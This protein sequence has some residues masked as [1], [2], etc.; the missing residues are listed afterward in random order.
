MLKN[1]TYYTQPT[2]NPSRHRVVLWTTL[3]LSVIILGVM[4]ALTASAN[5]PA[6]ADMRIQSLVSELQ[7]D[8]LT[9][10]RHAAQQ[11]L[12]ELG[13]DAVPAL[14][15]ALRS[16]NAVL[17]RNAADML[18]FIASPRSISSLQYSLGNDPV[19][20]V[21]RNAA[22]AL[23][24][25]DS[26][27][28]VGDLQKASLFDGSNLVRQTAQD[29]IARIRTRLALTTGIPETELNAFTVSPQS[30]SNI[31]VATRRDIVLTQDGG[32][33][34]RTFPNALPSVSNTLTISPTNPQV[35]YA[36]ID[37]SGMYKSVD[38]GRTWNAMN[39]GLNVA[40]GAR[41]VV[42]AITVDP[43]EPQR[44]IIATGMMVGTSNVEFYS[45]GIMI[46]NNG[47][48]DWV[49]LRESPSRDA[50]TQL[51]LRGNQLYAL[52][53]DRVVKYQFN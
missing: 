8:R 32:K 24:E 12:E 23:G 9:A 33:T 30:P 39:N 19:P 34:W 4:V 16:D 29:S 28:A 3:L 20:S 6:A 22:F 50:L 35:L 11:D 5:P 1:P 40:P 17:R 10:S 14:M 42:T 21:R 48:E 2:F 52:A 41:F 13:E 44:V 25:I 53:G 15:V 18:S 45:T 7:E 26:F 46:S 27:A 31:Y 38:G 36:G 43:T 51:A 37:S 49:K 47:G